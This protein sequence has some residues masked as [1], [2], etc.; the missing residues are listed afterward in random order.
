MQLT[1]PQAAGEQW[2]VAVVTGV[3]RR[4]GIGAAIVRQLAAAGVSVLA[5]GWQA[6][7]A[8]VDTGIDE[9]GPAS[10]IREIT[11]QGGRAAWIAADLS[12]PAALQP[13]FMEAVQRFGTVSI[14]VNNAAY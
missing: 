2:P 5:T 12:D 8:S 7:D 11:S 4:Q 14:L 1:F 3:S 6:F 10:L 13:I 9:A